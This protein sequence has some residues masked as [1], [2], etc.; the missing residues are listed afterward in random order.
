MR[1]VLLSQRIS[2]RA[3]AVLEEVGEVVIAP[4]G[5]LGEFTNLVSEASAVVLGTSIKFT[6]ELMDLASELKV[7]SRTG[8]GVDNVDVRAATERGILVLNTPDANTVSVAEHTVALIAAISKQLLF[9]DKELRQGNFRARRL[10][11]PVD[12]DG[13]TLGLIG[14][15][16]IGRMVAEKCRNAFNMKVIGYDPYPVTADTIERCETIEEVLAKADYVSIHVPL[17][18]GTRNLIDERLLSL[19]KPTAYLIDTARGGI[20]CE[21]A[22]AK[23][24]KNR[25]IAGAAID[26]FSTEPPDVASELLSCPN[27]IL[28]PHSAA[29]TKECTVRVS[30]EAAEGVADYFRGK[31]PKS[32]VNREALKHGDGF[33]P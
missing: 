26:V 15:G 11:L 22:L 29:L 21:E 25:E 12:I 17:N 31:P 24:L 13:K 6:A 20:V 9:L 18:E 19:M 10:N 4:E 2:E 16:K 28:T 33:I 5:D 1:R 8:V 27:T 30:V 14:C 32:V 3:I 23:K 7:I